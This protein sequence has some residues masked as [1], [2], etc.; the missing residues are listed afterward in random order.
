MLREK[1]RQVNQR[2]R[3]AMSD[4]Y[5]DPYDYDIDNDPYPVWRRMRDEEP[6]YHNEKLGF[7]AL[8]R[9]ED[10]ERASLET[11]V[12]SSAK[13]NVI[14]IIR[15]SLSGIPPM[16]MIIFM[17]PPKHTAMRRLMSRGFTPRRVAALEDS[18]RT[19]A[20]DGLGRFGDGDVFDYLEDFGAH[21]PPKVISTLLGIPESEHDQM[22]RWSDAI[23][24]LAEGDTEQGGS[25]AGVD[26]MEQMHAY[27]GELA[28]V[29]R[30]R[31]EEDFLTTLIEAELTLP[32]GSTRP[33]NDM[34]VVEYVIV[35]VGAGSETVARFLGNAIVVLADSP[36]Q[37][38]LLVDDRSCIP[39]AVE[40]LLRF[41]PPSPVQ[42]R[43]VTRDVELHGRVIPEGSICALLTGSAG[44]DERR[45]DDPDRVDVQRD[46]G[47]HLS[48]GFGIHF[49][50]GAALA[51]LE[52]R[53]V[54]EETLKTFPSWVVDK[55]NLGRTHSSTVRGYAKV[56]ARF[57]SHR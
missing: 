43:Y 27:F 41:E 10:V 45:F 18:V 42:G 36:D 57:S 9:Y 1:C 54:L 13:G 38:D 23:M 19:M 32:D 8:S 30:R 21:I 24:H 5:Y 31:P 46:V 25:S 39:N 49:C 20:V 12:F 28:E 15:D 37:R 44:R 29:R 16:E 35:L 47:N 14:D 52:S 2:K 50:L 7:Y 51:R 56:P 3:D 11:E 48:L 40:E 17:D 34:E 22:R 26:A 4:L 55:E 6:V 53:V 33:L